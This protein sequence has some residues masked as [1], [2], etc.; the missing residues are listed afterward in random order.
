MSGP[1]S[2]PQSR[3]PPDKPPYHSP[4]A[5]G[6]QLMAGVAELGYQL[7]REAVQYVLEDTRLSTLQRKLVKAADIFTGQST[8][9]CEGL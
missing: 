7:D 8:F 5:V 1:G 9:F 6:R 4:A 3:H 2:G